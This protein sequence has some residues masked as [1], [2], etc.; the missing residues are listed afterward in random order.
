MDLQTFI[1]Q[2]LAT[3]KAVGTGQC[4]ELVDL[5][6]AEGFNNHTEYATAYEYWTNGIP[7]FTVTTT[8]KAGDIAV[9]VPHTVNGVNYPDGHIAVYV[10]SGVVFEQ[11]ADPDGSLPHEFNRATTYLA[12]YLTSQGG[13]MVETPTVNQGDIENMYQ[14]LLNRPADD[15]A[16]QTYNGMD[17]KTFV[18]ALLDSAEFQIDH[19]INSGDVVNMKNKGIDVSAV[20]G[21]PWK[22]GMY[23]A[24]TTGSAPE[25]T[26]LQSGTYKVN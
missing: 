8:P 11:N 1:N 2:V 4:G 12:G 7:G 25:A 17:W 13:N 10:G 15:S 20:E 24:S 21:Q 18:Y 6:L 14:S 3:K 22:T 19:T 16:L 26:V 5:W 23:A 9:Y